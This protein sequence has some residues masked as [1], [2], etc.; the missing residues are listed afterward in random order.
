MTAVDGCVGHDGFADLIASTSP[1]TL[2]ERRAAGRTGAAML[3][4]QQGAGGRT[5]IP[6]KLARY[7]GRSR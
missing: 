2:P 5:R 1:E 7:A 3:A 4:V 6:R